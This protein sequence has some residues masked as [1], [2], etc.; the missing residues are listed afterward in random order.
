[1]AKI[2]R[3]VLYCSTRQGGAADSP[4]NIQIGCAGDGHWD[5]EKNPPPPGGS[6]GEYTYRVDADYEDF[7]SRGITLSVEGGEAWGP[8][9]A[10]V[11]GEIESSGYSHWVPLAHGF[12]NPSA[13]L[14]VSDTDRWQLT[15]IDDVHQGHPLEDIVVTVSGGFCEAGNND[16]NQALTNGPIEMSLIGDGGGFPVLVYQTQLH[17]FGR[18]TPGLPETCYWHCPVRGGVSF[19]ALRLTSVRFSLLSDEIW[20]PYTIQVFGLDA[21]GTKGMLL[22]QLENDS[23]VSQDSH[24]G[25][26]GEH[27]QKYVSV[28]VTPAKRRAVAVLTE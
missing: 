1:M 8:R 27:L 7:L 2:V 24:G 6:S 5:C 10:F 19:S 21:S 13:P 15:M 4:G 26:T 22:G 28:P 12:E 25:P 23:G 16:G 3:L 14:W 17:T 20:K 9:D 18:K 11:V